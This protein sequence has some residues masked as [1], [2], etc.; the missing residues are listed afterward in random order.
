ME[1]EA[2]RDIARKEA[3]DLR[4]KVE[5]T[6]AAA[7][8]ASKARAAVEAERETARGEAAELRSRVAALVAEAA[9]APRPADG[10]SFVPI[11]A[12]PTDESQA[13]Q[14]RAEKAEA[15]AK[16]AAESWGRSAAAFNSLLQAIRRTPFL[17]PTVRV[18]VAE[19]ESLLEAAPAAAPKTA[20]I[21]LLDREAPMLEPLARELEADNLEVLIAHQPDEATLYLK[22]P[23]A[24]G[25]TAIVLDVLA[26]RPDQNLA[27]LVREWRHDQPGFA[28]FLTF[29]ADIAAEAER[30]QRLP[31]T[32]TAGYL[33]RPLQK[34]ALLEAIAGL[35]RR[36][37]AKR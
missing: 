29:R 22:T 34:A 31:S 4:Q 7:D 33:P 11:P 24:R 35:A 9:A 28:L 5:A 13:L 1:A 27:T 37:S 21:L 15:G 14:L 8:A 20:R 30:A 6:Q 23:D 3:A 25:L 10:A 17:P 26:L 12:P 18:S 19:A 2:E 36:S 32:A 16:A